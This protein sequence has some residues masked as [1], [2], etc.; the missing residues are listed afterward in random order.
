[1]KQCECGCGQEV[2]GRNHGREIRF[3]HGHNNRGENNYGW[4]GGTF[5][6]TNGYRFVKS[7]DHPRSNESGYVQEHILVAEKAL[8]HYLPT[9]AVVHHIDENKLNN[10]PG[11]LVIC[12]DE[13]YHQM[14]HRRSRALKSC[15]NAGWFRCSFCK[16]YDDPANMK[17]HIR[18]QGKHVRAYHSKCRNET[19]RSVYV[20]GSQSKEFLLKKR[21]ARSIA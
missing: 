4:K 15:G 21:L 2:S 11:N 19:R 20:M 8:G 17:L 3:I 5:V 9:D 12:P 18:N 14:L 1:M 16:T 10:A 13:S 6:A 7:P